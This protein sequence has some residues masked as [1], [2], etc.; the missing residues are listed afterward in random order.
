MATP[1][2][3]HDDILLDT[4]PF[5]GKKPELDKNGKEVEYKEGEPWIR[6]AEE[7]KKMKKPYPYSHQLHDHYLHMC[8][9][10]M[11]QRDTSITVR[12]EE[13]T[14]QHK[15]EILDA[16]LFSVSFQDLWELYNY[17]YLEVS[18]VSCYCL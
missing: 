6:D 3:V 14:F 9:K 10:P 7:L 17:K 2:D 11:R 15:G 13:E 4:A 5:L 12:F 18:I 8:D 1:D 16:M